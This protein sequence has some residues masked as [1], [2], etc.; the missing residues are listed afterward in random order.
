MKRL[1]FLLLII[2]AVAPVSAQENVLTVV[3]QRFCAA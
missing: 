3:A 2:F 1:L